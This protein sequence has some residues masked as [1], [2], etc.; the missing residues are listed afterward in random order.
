MNTEEY[1]RMIL[2]AVAIQMGAALKRI[3][4]VLSTDLPSAL[5]E[6][7]EVA[8]SRILAAIEKTKN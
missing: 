4:L 8:E 6:D 5:Q 2:R 3:Q 1:Q 7:L